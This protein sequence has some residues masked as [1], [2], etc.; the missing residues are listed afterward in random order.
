MSQGVIAKKARRPV[1]ANWTPMARAM[2]PM[3]PLPL[4]LPDSSRMASLM[5]SHHGGAH[6]HG[7]QC[8]D[9]NGKS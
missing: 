3:M 9:R 4:F 6:D 5:T 8:G 2:S 1:S 7:D